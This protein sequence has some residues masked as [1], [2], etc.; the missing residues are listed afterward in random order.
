MTKSQWAA[1]R[2]II[3]EHKRRAYKPVKLSRIKLS[4]VCG[5]L[6]LSFMSEEVDGSPLWRA[7]SYEGHIYKIGARGKVTR[8]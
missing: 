1:V 7:L 8:R 3:R 5:V 2:G 6:T 4:S